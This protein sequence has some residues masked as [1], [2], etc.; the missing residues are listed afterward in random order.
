MACSNAFGSF[1]GDAV[2]EDV[3][4]GGSLLYRGESRGDEV[5]MRGL[6]IREATAAAFIDGGDAT[7]DE[8]ESTDVPGG[9]CAAGGVATLGDGK[10]GL[11]VDALVMGSE[12]SRVAANRVGTRSGLLLPLLGE[13]T[14]EEGTG[15]LGVTESEARRG[16]DTVNGEAVDANEL[17]DLPEPPPRVLLEGECGASVVLGLESIV[18]AVTV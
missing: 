1:V 3:N 5:D 16:E 7:V 4:A 8:P 6:I 11:S 14:E 18:T 17:D 2:G 9:S 10:A 12:L 13:E 15:E